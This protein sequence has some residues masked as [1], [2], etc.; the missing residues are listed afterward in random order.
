LYYAFKILEGGEAM[1]KHQYEQFLKH[2]A[3]IIYKVG[4]EIPIIR[5]HTAIKYKDKIY[6]IPDIKMKGGEYDEL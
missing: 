4:E 2:N 5:H 1:T 3:T 6:I